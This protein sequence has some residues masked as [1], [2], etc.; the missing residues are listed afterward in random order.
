[1]PK[2]WPAPWRQ[3]R[4][5]QI[6]RYQ[7][8]QPTASSAPATRSPSPNWR[9]IAYIAAPNGVG[10]AR[11][12][13]PLRLTVL[14]A[15]AVAEPGNGIAVANALA[16]TLIRL[17]P[18]RGSL[19][20]VSGGE[21]A[22]II[23]GRLGIRVLDLVGEAMPGLPLARAGDLTV[24]TKSGGFGTEDTLQLLFAPVRAQEERTA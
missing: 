19:L 21:T 3:N 12:P 17:D 10:P 9:E 1:L 4:A 6:R 5:C 16:E 8:R 18:P 7:M 20:V 14:Q 11:L 22:Q 2:P 23:L 13:S 15:T 24:V